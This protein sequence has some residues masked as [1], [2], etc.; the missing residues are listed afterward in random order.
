MYFQRYRREDPESSDEDDYEPYIPVRERKKQKLK[1]ILKISQVWIYSTVF[2]LNTSVG[3]FL[4]RLDDKE[5]CALTKVSPFAYLTLYLPK[6]I[7]I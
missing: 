2:Q 5:Y 3:F 7:I 6:I 1:Q 4:L